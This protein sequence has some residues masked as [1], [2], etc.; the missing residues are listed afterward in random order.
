[1]LHLPSDL[2]T[3]DLH[4]SNSPTSRRTGLL[5]TAVNPHPNDLQ[6]A[7]E[8]GKTC[9]S[10]APKSLLTKSG[11]SLHVASVNENITEAV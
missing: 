11:L 9:A 7:H 3:C 10:F 8:A 2:L 6:R 1:M 4:P 5:R